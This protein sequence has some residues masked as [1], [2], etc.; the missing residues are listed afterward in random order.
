MS[1]IWLLNESQRASEQEGKVQRLYRFQ[2][3]MELWVC[4][5]IYSD[6]KQGDENILQQLLKILNDALGLVDVVQPWNLQGQ[7]LLTSKY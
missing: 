4:V 6:L 7:N 2:K 5:G 1:H 3:E